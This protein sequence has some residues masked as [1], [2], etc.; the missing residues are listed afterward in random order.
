M[1]DDLKEKVEGYVVPSSEV[2]ADTNATHL[3]RERFGEAVARSWF[4]QVILHERT[5][6]GCSSFVC[7]WIKNNYLSR[8]SDEVDDVVFLTGEKNDKRI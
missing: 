5:L 6:Y 7:A 4:S 3:A 2:Y 8:L 1:L